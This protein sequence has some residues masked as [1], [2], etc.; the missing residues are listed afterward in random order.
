[1]PFQLGISPLFR[2]FPAFPARRTLW[3]ETLAQLL[4]SW[5]SRSWLAQVS[6]RRALEIQ[7]LEEGSE[8]GVPH[9]NRPGHL[10]AFHFPQTKQKNRQRRSASVSPFFRLCQTRRILI[11]T[12]CACFLIILFYLLCFSVHCCHCL[13]PLF[14]YQIK[15]A[16]GTPLSWPCDQAGK[17]SLALFSRFYYG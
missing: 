7:K 6:A 16:A 8:I 5:M 15:I 1:M 13:S 9:N 4:S 3:H 2:A 11:T 14:A 17:Q 10:H 12:F